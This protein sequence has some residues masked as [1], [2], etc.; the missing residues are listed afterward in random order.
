MA[1]EIDENVDP[2][3]SDRRIDFV[4]GNAR[5]VAPGL[6]MP[7][8]AGGGDVAAI[9]VRIGDDVDRAAGG[10]GGEDALDEVPDRVH[11]KIP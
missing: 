9:M 11:P 1:A 6:H 4:V 3:V 8:H 7:A 2:V 5:Y 10:M